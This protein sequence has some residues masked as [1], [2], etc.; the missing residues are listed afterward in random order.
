LA[1]RDVGLQTT[2]RILCL[3]VLNGCELSQETRHRSLL[4]VWQKG[5]AMDRLLLRLLW[6]EDGPTAVEYAVMLALI[7]GVCLAGIT[8]LGTQTRSGFEDSQTKINS[9][10]SGS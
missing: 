10:I 1:K 3:K 9:A 4:R 7:V 6:D 5:I 8:F 2:G